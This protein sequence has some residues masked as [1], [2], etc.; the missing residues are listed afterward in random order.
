VS[1][2]WALAA[3]A[4][5]A[6]GVSL[7]PLTA[8]SDAARIKEVLAA[9][10]GNHDLLPSEMVVALAESGNVTWGAVDGGRLVGYVLA[11]TGVS[12]SDG[13][14]VH[15]HQLA[16]LPEAR[17]R[18]IGYALKLAQ[19]AQAL[20]QGIGLVRWTFDPLG[21][22]NAWFNMVKLGATA[23]RFLPH[24]YGE[25]K[26]DLN[27]GEMTDRLL[28]RWELERAPPGEAMQP[29]MKLVARSVLTRTGP[30]DAPEPSAISEPPSE[31]AAT[32][33]IPRDYQSLRS[34][35]HGLAGSW[36]KACSSAL[37]ACF[38]AGLV[39]TG[40]TEDSAYVLDRISA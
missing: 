5:G 37:S 11:W 26:D 10:W 20:E 9:T 14:H 30:D 29:A 4:A 38:E 17:N 1:D 15:S 31:G 35:D 18:G 24:F 33:A 34:G 12:A 19:R 7:H 39:V 3:E 28:I 21:A 32:I 25:M 23:D 16:T 22:R 13:L 2:A 8:P 27:S 40:F 36:R 6:A